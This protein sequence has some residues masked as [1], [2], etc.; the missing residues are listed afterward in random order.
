MLL[1]QQLYAAGLASR[2]IR[3]FLPCVDAGVST[4]ETMAR[5]R[6]ER[7]RIDG[8]IIGLV[9]TRDRLD[10]VIESAAMCGITDAAAVSGAGSRDS[11][12][13]ASH[14]RLR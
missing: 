9:S 7:D 11:D 2:T 6:A 12:Q 1:I 4:P 3:T 5:L 10:A 14:G 13:E 8:Q